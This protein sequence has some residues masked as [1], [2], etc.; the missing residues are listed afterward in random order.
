MGRYWERVGGAW[1]RV[2][3]AWQRAWPWVGG[4]VLAVLIGAY[5]LQPRDFTRVER[6]RERAERE[7]EAD[8][9][10]RGLESIKALRIAQYRGGRLQWD[11]AAPLA[12]VRSERFGA[13]A[14][15]RLRLLYVIE[16]TAHLLEAR[17]PALIVARRAYFNP[18]RQEWIFLEGR[19]RQGRRDETFRALHWFTGDGRLRMD[20]RRRSPLDPLLRFWEP[21]Y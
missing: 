6:A 21:S 8:A 16:P 2:V 1:E 13:F 14:V 7:A 9:W 15:N 4:I 18:R 5:L 20:Q 11:I 10:L 3:E 12:R 17:T 19:F